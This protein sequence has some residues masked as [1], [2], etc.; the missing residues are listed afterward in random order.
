MIRHK[1]PIFSLKWNKEGDYLL[2]GSV[3]RTAIVW[4]LKTGEWKQQF[5]FHSG[6]AL[7]CMCASVKFQVPYDVN[8]VKNIFQLQLWMLI[9]ETILLLQHALLMVQYMSAR[10]ERTNQSKLS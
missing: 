1:G 4:E 8:Q 3:D 6:T 9:G 7:L 5:E 2:S 10:S